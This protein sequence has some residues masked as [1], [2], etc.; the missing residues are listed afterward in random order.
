[1][2][3][4]KRLGQWIDQ[5]A[6]RSLK[7]IGR[8]A[9]KGVM[10]SLIALLLFGC[11]SRP[12]SVRL[13]ELPD[14]PEPGEERQLSGDISEV[15]PPAIFSDL[16]ELIADVRPQI[17]IA[18]PKLNQT[19]TATTLTP[20]LTLR[21][22]SIY[23]DETLNLGPHLQV[24][25]DNQPAQ[26][27]Y[28]LDEPIEFS[29]LAPGSHTL[30]VLAVKPWGESFKNA[31]AY[32]QTTFHIFAQTSENTP[33]AEQP[34]LI[35][36]EPQGTYGAQP[37]LLDFYLNN[38]PLHSI[39]ETDPDI[40]DWRIRCDVN[41][42]SF[43]FNQWQ[44]VYLQG[45]KPGQN[46]VR[47]ELIDEQGE[48]IENDF[49]STVRLI[50]FDPEL[51][52]TLAR[53]TRGELSIRKVGQIVD[54]DYEPPTEAIAPIEPTESE[55]PIAPIAP[56]EPD[57]EIEDALEPEK[58]I[59][60]EEKSE[61]ETEIT[62]PEES[63]P[64]R[65]KEP[66]EETE[67]TSDETGDIVPGEFN[68]FDKFSEGRIIEEKAIEEAA[69]SVTE[70]NTEKAAEDA[71]DSEPSPT[72]EEA[73]E[74]L[75]EDSN[76][77]DNSE[78]TLMEESETDSTKTFAEGNASSGDA[79]AELST[80]AERPTDAPPA[81]EALEKEGS[82]ELPI[83]DDKDE[84]ETDTSADAPP[85]ASASFFDRLQTSW[86]SLNKPKQPSSSEVTPVIPEQPEILKLPANDFSIDIPLLIPELQLSDLDEL[87]SKTPIP[88]VLTTTETPTEVLELGAESSN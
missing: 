88:D 45:F 8:I 78:E 52:D 24:I 82:D 60:S 35:Y 43:L 84:L 34:Q 66:I 53:L 54:P 38:A 83:K 15:A 5:Q 75:E 70:E 12:Q 72:F 29:E 87:S 2:G 61:P 39:A 10:G 50:D 30:R 56:I 57:T 79:E 28:S 37:V 48:L 62:L 32:A 51:R 41:G 18:S 42:Q 27:L 64:E 14:I 17:A 67:E 47:L 20:K 36:S 76:G 23:K 58:A 73:S 69:E 1:M 63:L 21:G 81:A 86:R 13:L 59:E 49:N 55:E 19:L 9:I 25:L 44:P 4:A 22:L 11:A 77:E 68:D 40:K 65:L 26:T 71:T 7:Y 3:F 46:W 85:S 31:E 80:A 74:T 16:D 6:Q 33:K